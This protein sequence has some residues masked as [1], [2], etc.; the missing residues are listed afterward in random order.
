VFHVPQY[1]AWELILKKISL[2]IYATFSVI[3]MLEYGSV[4]DKKNA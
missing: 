3:A 2:R 1:K 4:F